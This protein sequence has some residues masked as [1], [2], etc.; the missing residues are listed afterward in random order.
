MWPFKRKTLDDLLVKKVKIRG[1]VFKI[2]K[3]DPVSHLQG[4][5]SLLK[6][7]EL[8]KI[9]KKPDNMVEKSADQIKQVRKLFRDVL[10]SGVVSPKLSAK[11]DGSGYFVDELLG[12]LELSSQLAG[13][14]MGFTYGKKKSKRKTLLLNTQKTES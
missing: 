12:D 8:Y 2:K 6:I 1:L 9:Q 10:L 7:H 11:P 3:I 5:N 13:E 4:F 14:I